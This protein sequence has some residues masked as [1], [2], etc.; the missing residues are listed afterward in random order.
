MAEACCRHRRDSDGPSVAIQWPVVVTPSR[1]SPRSTLVLTQEKPRICT[2]TP[3][4][5]L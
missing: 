5:V 4:S 1:R 3:S 2:I